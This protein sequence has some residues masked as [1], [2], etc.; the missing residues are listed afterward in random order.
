MWKVRL[1][2]YEDMKKQFETSASESDPCFKPFLDNPAIYK[3][4]V[5]DSN[6]VAQEQGVASLVNILQFGGHDACLRYVQGNGRCTW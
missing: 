3:K 1:A 5:T 2:A 4:I 6:V